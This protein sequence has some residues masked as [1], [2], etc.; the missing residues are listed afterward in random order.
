[1]GKKGKKGKKK[2]GYRRKQKKGRVSRKLS[3]PGAAESLGILWTAFNT[4]TSPGLIGAQK[5]G[6]KS[7]DGFKYAVKATADVVKRESTPAVVGLVISN[8]DA[9]PIFGKLLSK[10][11]RRLDRVSKK[12]LG[13]RL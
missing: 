7:V 10:P 11:K 1:M 9:I 13:M 3:K 4:E 6:F 8:I 5:A 2:G 12:Y